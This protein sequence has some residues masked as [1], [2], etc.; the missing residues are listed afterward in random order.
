MLS[1]ALLASYMPARALLCAAP[2]RPGC[3]PAPSVFSTPL[4][5]PSPSH[6]PHR[7]KTP[8]SQAPNA[9]PRTSPSQA[10]APPRKRPAPPS[11]CAIA[12]PPCKKYRQKL[13]GECGVRAT[14]GGSPARGVSGPGPDPLLVGLRRRPWLPPLYSDASPIAGGGLPPLQSSR[15]TQSKRK[16]KLFNA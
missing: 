6:F 7:P 13:S 1:L 8:S 11:L 12:L 16:G 15:R 14:V 3:P 5:D 2:D 10:P 9:S 4:P